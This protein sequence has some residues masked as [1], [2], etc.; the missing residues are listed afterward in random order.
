MEK[1]YILVIDEGTTGTRALIIDREGN[2]ISQEYTEI[3]QFHPNDDYVEQDAV[4]IWEKT[5][6]VMLK[7]LSK[8]DVTVEELASIGITN[9]R[10]TTVLWDRHTGKPIYRAIV[11]QDTRTAKYI[12]EIRE[13]WGDILYS[14]TGWAISPVYSSLMIKWI[15]DEVD[16]ARQKAEDG[17]LLFGTIDTWLI[18]NLTKGNVHATSYSN[19]SVTGSYDIKNLCWY[20]EWLK[21]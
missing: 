14:K 17:D 10:A 20:E 18:W 4:E 13:Q 15:L 5:L 21:F 16:G 12:D 19:A 9:Q 3:T 8:V 6:S 7:A 2:I 11:W 1:K